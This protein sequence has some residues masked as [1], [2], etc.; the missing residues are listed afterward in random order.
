M[1]QFKP[2]LYR[3]GY[4][5]IEDH[6]LIGDGSTAALVGRDGAISWMCVP[7]FDSQ[8]LFCRIL[9]A[10][11]GGAFTIAPEDLV[12]SRQYYEP[13][14]AVLVTEMRG[15]TG[16]LRVTDALSLRQGADLTEDAAAGRCELVRVVEALQ[17][18]V[19]TRI[20]VEPRGDAHVGT[21]GGGLSIYSLA[22]PQLDLQLSSSIPLQ[23]LSSVTE[24]KAGAQLHLTLRWSGAVN[25]HK[26][27]STEES[28]L[29]TR[30]AWRRWAARISFEGP[31]K[32]VVRRSALTLK[33]L[34]HFER[35]AL[36]A[37][38]TS[39]LPA[40]IG[41]ERNWDYRYAWIRDA[42]FA[43]YALNRIG[44]PEEAAG[45]LGWALDAF[46]RGGLPR[47]LYDL[48]GSW[49][50]R[51]RL[52]AELE[53]YRGSRP[54]RWGNGAAEQV[55]HDVYG[56]VLD[57]AYQWAAR[58]GEIDEALW[59]R[60]R[61]LIEAAALEWRNTDHGIWEV[62]TPG[63]VFT[64][65][66]ALCQVALDRGVR[67]A[68]RFKF[69]GDCQSWSA[70]ADEIRAAILNEA[71]D[72]KLNSLTESLSGGGLDASLL[73][74]PLRRVIPADHPKMVAT[75]A[76]I[77]T[78][79]GAGGGLLYRYLPQISPDGL[80]GREGAFLLCSFWLVDNLAYQG[81]LDEAMDLFGSLCAR[82]NALGL[83]PEQID[84]SSGA[85][86]GN[87]PH[88]FTHVGLISSAVSLTRLSKATS[89]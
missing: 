56:E 65:S 12:E 53:G 48:D 6:G 22:R 43:V 37:A 70:A 16:L 8:P 83:L 81:R 32:E 68:E 40:V 73:C 41:G 47:E 39:S 52:D 17:G 50:P 44:C 24:L 76:A 45:F 75:T 31:H 9:D 27:V 46:E 55:Q 58:H 71:W 11:N 87:F 7:R 86:L 51:E 19:R 54:V 26:P 66:A 36:V 42:A 13:E 15:P 28:L 33:L 57:C 77:A 74:L 2:V 29:A 4:L 80:P 69:P 60:L 5:P 20:E 23:A 63:R 30:D 35:G 34:N 21:R 49:S 25:R 64:Y 84:P 82:T 79:L 89:I 1:N 88:A 3:D 10:G 67:M 85:F 72:E 61:R 38:P 18:N 62:R 78:G 14:T 59:Q